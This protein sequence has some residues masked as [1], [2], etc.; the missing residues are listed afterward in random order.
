MKAEYSGPTPRYWSRATSVMSV[1]RSLIA[2]IRA[3]SL[4]SGAKPCF[5]IVT[6]SIAATQ[7]SLIR[8][9]LDDIRDTPGAFALGDGMLAQPLPNRILK[10]VVA[11]A[12]RAVD[13][14]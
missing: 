8:L 4:S 7:K 11:G 2:A 10:E 9:F 14:L 13:E 3:N 6:V 1:G 12:H 5:A